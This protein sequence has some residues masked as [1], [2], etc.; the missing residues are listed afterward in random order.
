MGT[1]VINDGGV[2]DKRIETWPTPVLID[3]RANWLGE[4]PSQP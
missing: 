4:M 2:V 3:V 1:D